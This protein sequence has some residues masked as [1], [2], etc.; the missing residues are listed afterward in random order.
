M[1]GPSPSTAAFTASSVNRPMLYY[2][3]DNDPDVPFCRVCNDNRM[4]HLQGMSGPLTTCL[5]SLGY[6]VRSHVTTSN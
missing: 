3:C 5:L 4:R 1:H 2:S 6:D